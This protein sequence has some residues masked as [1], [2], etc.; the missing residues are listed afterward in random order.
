MEPYIGSV[1]Y[2][3][4]GQYDRESKEEQP[5]T[6]HRV[7]ISGLKPDSVYEKDAAVRQAA[8]Q[9]LERI[10]DP[11]TAKSIFPYLQDNDLQIRMRVARAL[12]LAMP[13]SLTQK[14]AKEVLNIRQPPEIRGLLIGAL[15][16]HAQ[17]GV[18]CQTTLPIMESDASPAL[19]NRSTY[20]FTRFASKSDIPLL[21]KLFDYEWIRITGRMLSGR[22][23]VP[24]FLTFCTLVIFDD[25]TMVSRRSIPDTA[26]LNSR[27]RCRGR[28]G[29]LNFRICSSRHF[30]NSHCRP[31][32]FCSGRR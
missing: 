16:L 5:G 26:S 24:L 8:A 20:A 14:V 29:Y 19:R 18:M 3:L 28:I 11:D 23:P 2:G 1:S 30:A 21:L 15:Q 31:V 6:I 32:S 13:D 4:S 27:G 25:F 17:P 9:A 12:E 22:M 10:G 7:R